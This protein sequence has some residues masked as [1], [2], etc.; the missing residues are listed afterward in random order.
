[1]MEK[2]KDRNILVGRG[3]SGANVIRLQPPFCMSMDDAKY[4]LGTFSE[5]AKAYR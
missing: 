1:M 5:I 4:F 3:G 2:L